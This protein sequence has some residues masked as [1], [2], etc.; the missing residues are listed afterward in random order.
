MSF[1]RECGCSLSGWASKRG[2][3]ALAVV[4]GGLLVSARSGAAP[5]Y[6]WHSAFPWPA[7]ASSLTVYDARR[8][9]VFMYGSTKIYDDTNKFLPEHWEWNGASGTWAQLA[10]SGRLPLTRQ[11]IVL[12]GYDTTR[13]LT[14]VLSPT[15]GF[16]ERNGDGG[17]WTL[18]GGAR[19]ELTYAEQL[20]YDSDRARFLVLARKV[21]SQ[22]PTEIWEW[23][24]VA[25]TLVQRTQTGMPTPTRTGGAMAYDAGRHRLVMVGGQTDPVPPDYATAYLSDVWEWDPATGAWAERAPTGNHPSART[26]ARAAYHAGLGHV[27]LFGGSDADWTYEG[28][29]GLAD[30]WEWDGTAGAWIAHAVP[31]GSPTP[32]GG[33]VYSLTYDGFRGRLVIFGGQG[34]KDETGVTWQDAMEWDD[35]TGV[36]LDRSPPCGR[37]APAMAYDPSSARV[38]MFGGYGSTDMNDLW[39]WSGAERT[40]LRLNPPVP[41]PG[42]REYAAMVADE[43]RKMLVLSDG[44]GPAPA[45]D[46]WE[47]DPARVTWSQR[48]TATGSGRR[49]TT[50]IYDPGRAKVL[51][52]GGS[53]FAGSVFEWDAAA[54]KWTS[55]VTTGP[56]PSKRDAPL[57][58]FDVARDRLV[59]YGGYPS[60]SGQFLSDTWE[61]NPADGTWA[62]RIPTSN[63]TPTETFSGMYYDSVRARVV[64]LSGP[65]SWAANTYLE[66]ASEWDGDAGAWAPVPIAVDTLAGDRPPVAYWPGVAFDS[67]RGV[68]TMFG[69][70]AL[71]YMKETWELQVSCP[72]APAACVA[73]AVRPDGGVADAGAADSIVRDSG[74]VETAN[75][76]GAADS[77]ARD[78]RSND[79]G[80]PDAGV[81]DAGPAA[82]QSTAVSDTAGASPEAGRD[83][84]PDAG[85]DSSE[86]TA[87]GVFDGNV[88]RHLTGAA[89]ANASSGGATK[90]S[91]CTCRVDG[92][93][94]PRGSGWTMLLGLL[95][96][97]LVALRRRSVAPAGPNRS[98]GPQASAASSAAG[99][100]RNAERGPEDDIIRFA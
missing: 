53:S 50:L 16:W 71:S 77:V 3:L 55:R 70:K 87:G 74:L 19:P 37:E 5:T 21:P 54:G 62:Q 20:I 67:S 39:A 60:G 44:Y 34:Y 9:R 85:A 97:G 7:Q 8:Q 80:P 79:S 13:G 94:A 15:E 46:T 17:T 83:A 40:W 31:A 28:K 93:P 23:D 27:F 68:A 57:G 65:S 48:T 32:T 66:T 89:D 99:A 90:S 78:L 41:Q 69:G 4:A 6:T 92:A 12:I 84:A 22:P 52:F 75:R 61:W 36:W 47:L 56:M 11:G 59:L 98:S 26:I 63:T 91:G 2:L 81:A 86:D 10:T 43:S 82:D 18:N 76:D 49:Y 14:V 30:L 88:D 45:G 25:G 24:P 95:A 29:T 35:K 38:F 73:V 51:D 1:R 33:P 96:C 72:P 42:P 58:A 64:M 100:A